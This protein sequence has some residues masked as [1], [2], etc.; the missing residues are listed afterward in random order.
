MCVLTFGFTFRSESPS[1][2]FLIVLS[3]LYNVLKTLPVSL[4]GNVVLVY[5]NMCQLDGLRAAV[6]DLPFPKPWDTMWKSIQ[7]VLDRFHFK[8]HTDENCKLKYNPENSLLA[9]DNSEVAEQ[10]FTWAGRFKKVLCAMPKVHHLFFLHRMV[11]RRNAYTAR[12]YR[13]G[14]K[15]LLPKVKK[16]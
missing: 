7:K 5:D 9:H 10:T 15:P 8:N 3:W 13:T 2:V 12:C 4:W 6:K 1:Q 11:K 14:K 16:V